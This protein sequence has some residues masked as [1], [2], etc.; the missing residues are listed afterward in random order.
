MVFDSVVLSGS[1][2][3]SFFSSAKN[4]KQLKSKLSLKKTAEKPAKVSCLNWSIIILIVAFEYDWY[5]REPG[6]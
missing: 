2:D 1:V 3:V 4:I 5:D 6:K